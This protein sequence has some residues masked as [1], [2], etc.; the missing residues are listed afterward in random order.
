MD[1]GGGNKEQ[2]SQISEK[3]KKKETSNG[4]VLN[5]MKSSFVAVILNINRLNSP[6][7]KTD[8][9]F[10]TLKQSNIVFIKLLKN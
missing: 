7:S 1:T 5:E 8:S 6:H 10:L 2:H 4:N 9:D 3:T